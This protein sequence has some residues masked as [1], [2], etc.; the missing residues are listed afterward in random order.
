LAPAGPRHR[1]R[2][3]IS[4]A[5][6]QIERNFDPGVADK[7]F[8]QLFGEH[9]D[10]EADAGANLQHPPGFTTQAAD[11]VDRIVHVGNDRRTPLQQRQ[12]GWRQNDFARGALEQ[13][14]SEFGFEFGDQPTDVR[15]R[16]AERACR[17]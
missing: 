4:L 6:F 17:S 14:R 13:P 9:I 2:N 10:S 15:F 12:A 11:I 1:F 5:R 16:H 8:R 7:K 3:Q